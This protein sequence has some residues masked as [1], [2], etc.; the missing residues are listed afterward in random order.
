MKKEVTEFTTYNR[1]LH[2]LKALIFSYLFTFA[3][4]FIYSII[5]AYTNISDT[6]IPAVVTGITIFS[7][8]LSTVIYCGRI[9]TAGLVNGIIISSIYLG[10]VYVLGSAFQVGFT[11]NQQSILL[12]ISVLIVGGVGGIIGVN[13][14]KLQR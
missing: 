14:N 9:A 10:I 3:L 7:I 5:L 11:L 12:I 1:F 6:T 8:F 2:I 13:F 4:I